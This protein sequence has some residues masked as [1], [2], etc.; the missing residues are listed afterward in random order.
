MPR[1]I[2]SKEGNAIWISHLDLMRVLQRSFRR[3]GLL[4]KH[5]QGFTPHPMLSLALPLSVGVSSCCEVMDFT[6]EEGQNDTE[7]KQRLNR[8]L[9]E[10]IVIREVYAEG[11]KIKALTHLHVAISLEYDR[12][13]PGGAVA[14]LEKL[15]ARE[16]IAIEKKTKSGELVTQNIRSMMRDISFSVQDGGTL[17]MECTVCAQNPSLNPLL[18]PTAICRETPEYA[19]D[20]AS[21]RRLAVLDAQGKEFR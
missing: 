2:F 6:L 15:F 16:T 13:I 11:Q 1:A 5:S 8:V 21:I 4:L 10:G 14:A 12:G 20:F 3:A 17:L 19:P 18:I 9:P 7:L